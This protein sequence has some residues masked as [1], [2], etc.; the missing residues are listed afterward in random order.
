MAENICQL[1]SYIG[2]I[3]GIC[4]GLHKLA[5]NKTNNPIKIW[6]K[7][8]N[9]FKRWNANG[10]KT[11]EKMLSIISHQGNA[12]KGHGE[13]MYHSSEKLPFINLKTVYVGKGVRKADVLIY[14]YRDR[15]Q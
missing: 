9:V 10:Q 12:N 4:K 6:A 14:C 11:Y 13:G 3:S 5:N 8:I 15:G 7:Y 1:Y 2:L